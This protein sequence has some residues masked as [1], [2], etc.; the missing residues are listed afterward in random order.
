MKSMLFHRVALSKDK[1]G[2][3]AIANKG[4]EIN[5]PSGIIK[6]PY[7]FEFAGIP[8]KY[9]FLEGELE[10]KLIS[11]L[12]A[13]LLELGKGFAFIGRQYRITLSNRHFYVDLVFYHYKLKC[14]VLIDLLCGVQHK[15]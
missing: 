8:E 7:V 11:N 6:Q 4:A 10:E 14:F 3:L 15:N 13:F 12:E 2:V 1:E 9:P 5:Q